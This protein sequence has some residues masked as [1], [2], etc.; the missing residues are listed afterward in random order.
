VRHLLIRDAA[1]DAIPKRLRAK[2]HERFADWLE[3][4]VGD[5]V[6]EHDEILGYHLEQACRYSAE[7]RAVE[8]AEHELAERAARHL[9]DAGRRA[10]ARRDAAAAVNLLMRAAE[11]LPTG[12][13]TRLRL[14][15]P[16]GQM[17]VELGDMQRGLAVCERVQAEATA[18]GEPGVAAE[19][20]IFANWMRQMLDP[21]IGGEAL[22]Q[23]GDRLEPLMVEAGDEVVLAKVHDM[24]AYVFDERRRSAEVE[25]EAERA[26]HYAGRAG[27]R[28]LEVEL[29]WWLL[30]QLPQGPRPVEEAIA[31]CHELQPRIAGDLAAEAVYA[32]SLA[33]LEAMRGRFDEARALLAAAVA[34][35]T[36]LGLELLSARYALQIHGLV[37]LL[38]GCPRAAEVPLHRA[39]ELA[40]PAG[41]VL[42]AGVAAAVLAESLVAQ[43]RIPEAAELLPTA[44]QSATGDAVNAQ[45]RWRRAEALVLARG[46]RRDEA[47]LLAR[48]AVELTE[49]TDDLNLQGA[50][51][52]TLAEVAGDAAAAAEALERFE[53]KGNIVSASAARAVQARLT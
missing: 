28:Y 18:A 26:I 17:L 51:L 38:A 14:M 2:L 19:A 39:L 6:A 25:R 53:R 20:E 52:L 21:S 33:H 34:S 27:R 44:R 37:E 48:D 1:Y 11:L 16:T 12:D 13:A 31:R 35:R 46:E 15:L 3:T 8:P 41:D 36:K 47:E 32:E 45:V 40:M 4:K 5:R 30:W 50:A 22:L 42:S 9:G 29:H 49:P 24:R 10:L 7:L 23:A 43:G